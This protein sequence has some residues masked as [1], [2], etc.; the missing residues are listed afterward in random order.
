MKEIPKI[1]FCIPSKNNRRY[2]E[3]CIP[4]IRKNA[5]R[6]DHDI[7]VFVDADN[8]GTVDWLKSV[9][10]KYNL[11]YIVN[12]TDGLYGIGK[13]Y[14][15]CIEESTTDIFMIFHADMMLGKD[16][17]LEAFIHLEKKKVVCSTRI[18]PP[19]H[20]EGPEK[21]VL[22]F[23]MWPEPIN[24]ETDPEGFKEKEFDIFVEECKY[25]LSIYNWRN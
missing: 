3:A 15:K 21:I 11:K 10:L 25:K 4:S 8:D 18:E 24:T 1:T 17:D 9:E 12:D 2:L 7:I 5:S 20:P 23:G 14:D 6:D 22:D 13:A 16:A 19:L